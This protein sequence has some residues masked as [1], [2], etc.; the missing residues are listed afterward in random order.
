MAGGIAE[1]RVK[2]ILVMTI[3]IT[4]IK[5]RIHKNAAYRQ[6]RNHFVTKII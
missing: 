3:T 2:Y 6:V 5:A 4:R 1:L